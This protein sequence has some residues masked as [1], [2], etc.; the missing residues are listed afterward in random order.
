MEGLWVIGQIAGIKLR[1][2]EVWILWTVGC[3]IVV[4][5]LLHE[6][7]TVHSFGS[8]GQVTSEAAKRRSLDLLELLVQN[9]HSFLYPIEENNIQYSP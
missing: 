4:N 3:H 2:G 5:K 8:R 1:K 9:M 6:V 7:C